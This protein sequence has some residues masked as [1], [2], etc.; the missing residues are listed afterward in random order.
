M[1]P[2]T[3]ENDRRFVMIAAL[4]DDW[5]KAG[6]IAEIAAVAVGAVALAFVAFGYF[7][8]RKRTDEARADANESRLL[9]VR[10]LEAAESERQLVL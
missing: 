7:H 3:G 6:I 4:S 10:A 8:E 9:S 1:I 2:A 5:L